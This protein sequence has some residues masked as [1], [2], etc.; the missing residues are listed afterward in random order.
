MALAWHYHGVMSDDVVDLV[1]ARD[2]ARSGR[3][4]AIREAAGLSL[5]ELGAA[6]GVNGSTIGRW[7]AGE[8]APRADAARRYAKLLKQLAEVGQ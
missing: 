3:A 2:L 6:L 1:R 8:R 7:E 5:A 4:K